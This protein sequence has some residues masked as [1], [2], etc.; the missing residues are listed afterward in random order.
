MGFALPGLGAVF[1]FIVVLLT[2]L[3][4]TNLVGRRLVGVWED[5]LNRIPSSQRLWGGQK[6]CGE[7]LFAVELLP[8]GR[9]D[10]VPPGRA[11]GV[12]GS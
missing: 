3:L 6:L 9:H 2:G 10:P 1:A 12:S 4:V 7:R 5:V 11:S 8:Q